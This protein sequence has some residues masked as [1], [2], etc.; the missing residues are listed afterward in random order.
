MQD[1]ILKAA[2]VTLGCRANQADTALICGKLKAAGLEIC[3]IRT[4][5]NPDVVILNTCTV[6]ASASQKSRQTARALR[7]KFPSAKLVVTG[8]S[9]D[10]EREQ[11]KKDGCADIVIPNSEKPEIIPILEGKSSG[12][13]RQ[14]KAVQEKIFSEKTY[15]YF[16]FRSRAFIKIQDGCNSFCTYCIVPYARGRERSRRHDEVIR[17]FR[18]LVD[19]GH[20]EIVVTGINIS[21]YDDGAKKLSDLVA[22]LAAIPGEFRIRLSSTEPHM[23]NMKLLGLMK[24]NPKICRFIHLPLQH[25]TNEILKAMGRNY[26]REEFAE[27]ANAAAAEIPGM[28][29]GTDVITGFPGETDKLFS[30]SCDFI[31][32]LPLANLHIFRFSPRKGTPAANF[33]DQIPQRIAKQRHGELSLVEDAMADKFMRSQ[34]GKILQVAIEKKRS[35]GEAEGW[36]DNYIRVVIEDGAGLV[37]NTLVKTRIT[38]IGGRN[39]LKGKIEI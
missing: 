38:G 26:A 21:T 12:S 18:S 8:C 5:V 13:H 29:I 33:A 7:K 30:E 27:F 23:E 39:I 16:P 28:H 4:A 14:G 17:E 15:P 2:T 36:S 34:A 9:C 22:E 6:T 3:D 20:K 19:S 1:R 24:G 25:G 10:T 37:K 31:R 11:W 35:S 32:S